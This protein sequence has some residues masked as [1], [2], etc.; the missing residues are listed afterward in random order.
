MPADKFNSLDYQSLSK[1]AKSGGADSSDRTSLKS[2]GRAVNKTSDTEPADLINPAQKSKKQS[3]SDAAF[4]DIEAARSE[5]FISVSDGVAEIGASLPPEANYAERQK[6]QRQEKNAEKDREL[7]GGERW[8]ARNGHG[9]TF[10]GLY[11]F[12][13]LV[14]FRP[15]ELIPSLSFL[16]ATA[17]YFA[18]VTLAV[19][20]P[21]Q[22]STEGTLTIFS[23]EIKCI[24][25]LTALA[26]LTIPLGKEA[27][28]S[29][30]IFSDIFIKVVLMFI[31]MVN[32]VRTRRRL[33]ALMWLS[34]TV[35]VYLSFTALDLYMKGE[36]KSE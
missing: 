36:M 3:P 6:Q 30:E 9:L 8:L 7:L 25:A 22:L 11:L 16:S 23:T 35:G 2:P 13:I 21:T 33:A 17:F 27:A 14:L 18:A 15:Y 12:S 29:W 20:L 26:F 34:L 32:V 28:Q 10:L 31:V 19:Y 4:R 5:N 1:N 24:L